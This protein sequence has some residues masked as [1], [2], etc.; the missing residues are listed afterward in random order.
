MTPMIES[1]GCILVFCGLAVTFA[2][3]VLVVEPLTR[4]AFSG[5]HVVVAMSLNWIIVLLATLWLPVVVRQFV[6]RRRKR[7]S[8]PDR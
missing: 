7:R 8:G 4:S 6:K 2:L 1:R 5:L 3:S